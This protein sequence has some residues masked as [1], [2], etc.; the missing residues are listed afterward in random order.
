LGL[1]SIPTV[2]E[3]IHII[4]SLRSIQKIILKDIG[5][6]VFKKGKMKIYGVAGK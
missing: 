3:N 5:E 1:I 2:K 6:D 4:F